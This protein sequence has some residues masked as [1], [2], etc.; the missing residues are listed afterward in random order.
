MFNSFF[1][2]TFLDTTSHQSP[3]FP[4]SPPTSSLSQI[5]IQYQTSMRYLHPW[6]PISLPARMVSVLSCLK[7]VLIIC[8][9]TADR[10]YTRQL[11]LYIESQLSGT[12]QLLNSY[13]PGG[14]NI[15]N[16]IIPAPAVLLPPNQPNQPNPIQIPE[17]SYVVSIEKELIRYVVRW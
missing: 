16:P 10:I 17:L 6:T 12:A 11:K 9:T 2:S 15:I 8:F 3:T 5:D 7:C 1:N 4:P 13:H 14:Q